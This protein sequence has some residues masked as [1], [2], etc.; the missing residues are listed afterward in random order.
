MTERLPLQRV[1]GGIAWFDQMLLAALCLAEAAVVWMISGAIVSSPENAKGDVP[2][3]LVVVLLWMTALLPTVLDALDVWDPWYR[4]VSGIAVALSLV[5]VVKIVS[6]PAMSWV[7][8]SWA[9]EVA[10]SLIL[11][12]NGAEVSAWGAIALVAYA[13][14]RGKSRAEPSVDSAFRLLRAGTVAALVGVCVMAAV[15]EERGDSAAAV[16]LFMVSALVAI[17]L[18][19]LKQGD[20]GS[21][22]QIPSRSMLIAFAP[23]AVVIGLGIVLAGLLSRDLLETIIWALGPLLWALGVI[24]RVIVLGVALIAL[25]I[26]TPIFWLLE[27][28]E[29]SLRA[30]RFDGRNPIGDDVIGEASQRANETP[31]PIR[32]IIAA[33]ILFLL[34]GG[35]TRFVLRRRKRRVREE[36]EEERSTL[37][38]VFDFN[39]WLAALLG[40]LG[41]RSDEH[42]DDP[43]NGLRRDPRWAATVKI[44]ERYREF[45]VWSK[46]RGYARLPGTTPAEHGTMLNRGLS[47]PHARDD[48]D[49]IALIYSRARYGDQPAPEADAIAIES[50]WR[51]LEQAGRAER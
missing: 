36:T 22:G 26:L 37:R 1:V 27:G 24:I 23:V 50:A 39:R 42:Q 11:R 32:Y 17:G 34:F 6:V 33:V 8:T 51:R 44:R 14:W 2:L 38:P 47:G 46:E 5:L 9:R 10:R 25:L 12:P 40:V 31:D 15:G 30:V 16:V 19:R 29:F 13:W 49:E 48:V 21:T 7:E 18:A 20:S 28:R 35:V 41:R 45:L 3:W 4:I 43:L